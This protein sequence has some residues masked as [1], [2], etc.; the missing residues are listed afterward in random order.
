VRHVY[1]ILLII[2]YVSG[3]R[4]YICILVYVLQ[5]YLCYAPIFCQKII[6]KGQSPDMFVNCNKKNIEHRRCDTY[7][8]L[9]NN[10]IRVRATPLYLYSYL[11]S[12]NIS[13]LHTIFFQKIIYKGHR[14]DMFV[15]R[16]TKS[17]SSTVGSTHYNSRYMFSK[18]GRFSYIKLDSG[19][20]LESRNIILN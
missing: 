7:I 6:Y 2:L 17:I 20:K 12:T 11:F 14:P 3:L 9:Y 18:W 8:V 10:S 5:T 4:P 15:E 19:I 13:V 16:K 1:I